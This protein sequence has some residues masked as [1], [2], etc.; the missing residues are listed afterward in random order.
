MN[1]NA[2]L[3]KIRVKYRSNP[4]ITQG[5]IKL[6]YTRY[7]M[8]K[9]AARSSDSL[10]HNEYKQCRNQAV[11]AV[12]V[13]QKAKKDFYTQ[14]GILYP[15]FQVSSRIPAELTMARLLLYTR[16]GNTE[17]PSNYRPI[18]VCIITLTNTV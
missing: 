7:H 8:H 1:K 10:I 18:P 2:P 17:D 6:M 12:L 5:I 11:K 15:T 4:W 13:V 16:E 3:K 9:K 14:R